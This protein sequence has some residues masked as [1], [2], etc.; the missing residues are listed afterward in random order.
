MMPEP[1]VLERAERT[2]SSRE[3]S[4]I[5]KFRE[6]IWHIEHAMYANTTRLFYRTHTHRRSVDDT[7]GLLARREA[8]LG[9]RGERAAIARAQRVDPAHVPL[10]E[11]H[12]AP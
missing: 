11:V 7:Q 3:W 12:A 6:T 1:G 10:A 2:M 9:S 8:R 4:V 5:G